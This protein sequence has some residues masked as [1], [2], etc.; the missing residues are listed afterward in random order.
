MDVRESGTVAK[1]S[2]MSEYERSTRECSPAQL[3]PA[4]RKALQN[5]FHEHDLGDMQSEVLLCCETVSK[6][7]NASRLGSWLSGNLDTTIHTGILLT[8]KT[9]FWIRYGDQSGTLLNEAHLDRIGVKFHTSLLSADV[10]LEIVGYVGDSNARV[11]GYIGMGPEPAAQKFCE[12]VKQA[13]L[14][15]NPPSPKKIFNWP[16]D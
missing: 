14:K 1:E 10:G 2:T 4:L 7:K 16:V 6:R 12:E 13:I 3:H 15:A 8:A 5:H 11:H 9:L